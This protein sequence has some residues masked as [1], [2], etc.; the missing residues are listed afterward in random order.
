MPFRDCLLSIKLK[1]NRCTYVTAKCRGDHI[2][3]SE[4]SYYSY[5]SFNELNI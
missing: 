2:N 5:F 4:I 1:V 3:A